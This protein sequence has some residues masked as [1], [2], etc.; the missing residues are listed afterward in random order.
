MTMPG[1]NMPMPGPDADDPMRY[2]RGDLDDTITR[3]AGARRRR[4]FRVTGRGITAEPNTTPVDEQQHG[5]VHSLPP[6]NLRA[7]AAQH[8][9]AAQV[10]RRERG[11]A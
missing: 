11:A 8:I 4:G 3:R 5:T 10:D 9:T 6:F 2:D 1:P 7:L